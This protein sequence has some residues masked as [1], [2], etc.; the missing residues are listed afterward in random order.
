MGLRA[1]SSCLHAFALS[2]FPAL[3]RR[4]CTLR[5]ALRLLRSPPLHLSLVCRLHPSPL[6]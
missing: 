3:V 4:Q 1:V 2:V 6:A 5:L